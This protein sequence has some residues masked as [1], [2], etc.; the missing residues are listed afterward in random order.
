MRS[1]NFAATSLKFL[2]GAFL[3]SGMPSLS[4]LAFATPITLTFADYEDTNF[5]Y[6]TGKE[7]GFQWRN[8][9]FSVGNGTFI[10]GHYDV[11]GN[12]LQTDPYECRVLDNRGPTGE[13]IN[14]P[15][16]TPV[17]INRISTRPFNVLS[18]LVSTYLVGLGSSKGGYI[19]NDPST[20]DP[21]ESD[22][23]LIDLTGEEWRGVSYL[24]LDIGQIGLL[25]VEEV[26]EPTVIPLLA[27]AFLALIAFRLH[28]RRIDQMS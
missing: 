12:I 19:E 15:C 25:T 2:L 23:A 1:V 9:I 26:S 27:L 4:G 13:Y 16:S 5:N 10:Q 7:K 6:R 14:F 24:T 11:Y 21:S 22:Y 18:V 17:R 3:L 28:A 8:E 20:P